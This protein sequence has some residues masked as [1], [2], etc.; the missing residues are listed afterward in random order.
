MP[1]LV[2]DVVS[3]RTPGQLA[4]LLDTVH[5]TVVECFGVP[6]RDRYQVL[7][8]HDPSHLVVQDAGLGIERS[9][10]VVLISITSRPRTREQKQAL[11]AG[12]ATR[13]ERD[14]GLAPSDLVV[15]ITVNADEDWSFG[16]GRAQFLTG[17]L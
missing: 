16:H 15:N 1:L 13:L 10:D 7:R 11:Y 5:T 8:E 9:D 14:C 6:Q 4:L 12:L 3:G 2:I 17:E